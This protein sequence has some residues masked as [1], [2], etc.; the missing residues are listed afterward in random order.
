MGEVNSGAPGEFEVPMPP[1]K[2]PL[3]KVA[4]SVEMVVL[5]GPLAAVIAESLICGRKIERGAALRSCC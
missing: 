1:A 3:T 2:T 5:T 4:S